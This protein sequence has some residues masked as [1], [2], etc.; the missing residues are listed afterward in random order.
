MRA[1][2]SRMNGRSA[3]KEDRLKLMHA[4]LASF[5]PIFA[6]YDG[7]GSELGALLR[8]A[9]MGA[10]LATAAGAGFDETLWRSEDPALNTAIADALRQRQLL[11][12]DGHHRYET[13]LALREVLRAEYPAAPPNANFNFAFMLLVNLH[14]PGLLVLPT[15]RLLL[16]T[17]AMQ[18]AFARVA[19]GHFDMVSMPEL[20]AERVMGLLARHEN[21]HAFVCYADGHFQLLTHPREMKD[22]LPVLDV[23]ALQEGVIAPLFAEDPGAA[24]GVES[25][26][27]YTHEVA[28]GV[29]AVNRGNA[30]AAIFL[31]ATP[32]PEVL[33]LAAAGVRLPQKST[34]FYPK[35]P[36]G[37]VMFNLQ[38]EV[39]VG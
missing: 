15:H 3:A 33:T 4:C 28:E 37:L 26:I 9:S 5:S 21:N 39:E 31:R 1:L 22:G 30:Q 27:R 16:L 23:Q 29:A 20:S 24:A 35:V 18:Q 7:E 11:I 14:D 6:L 8:R 13:M 36:T 32:V 25:H 17:P 10:P 34:Y 38:P 19:R 12:A 2:F